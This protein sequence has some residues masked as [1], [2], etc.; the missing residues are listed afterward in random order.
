MRLRIINLHLK[1]N[2]SHWFLS[3]IFWLKNETITFGISSF[4]R[5]RG[6]VSVGEMKAKI[7]VLSNE[8]IKVELPQ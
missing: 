3:I 2:L 4:E 8:L 7:L 1:Q 5:N 6:A